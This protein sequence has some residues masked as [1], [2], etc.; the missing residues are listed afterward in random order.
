MEEALKG[1]LVALFAGF[2]FAGCVESAP[3]HTEPIEVESVREVEP[4][5]PMLIEASRA[6]RKVSVA[7]I[8]EPVE[9]CPLLDD[10]GARVACDVELDGCVCESLEDARG[11]P[12]GTYC[13]EPCN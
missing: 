11:W 6:E 4:V 9:M 10:S 12:A 2:V 13:A 8:V 3:T 7:P 1:L 5:E